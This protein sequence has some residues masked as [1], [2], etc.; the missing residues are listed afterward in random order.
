M[1]SLLELNVKVFKLDVEELLGE[2][3]DQAQ[4]Q[5]WDV[6]P[7]LEGYVS[8]WQ[9]AEVVLFAVFLVTIVFEVRE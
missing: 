3:V 7:Q 5:Q 8:I 1:L 9:Q 4:F 2:L 6:Q